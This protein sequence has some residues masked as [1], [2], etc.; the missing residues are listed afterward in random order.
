MALKRCLR[1]QIQA[2]VTIKKTDVYG[3]HS[4]D[5]KGLISAVSDFT[6][7]PL[8]LEAGRVPQCCW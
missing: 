8:F 4:T 2:G 3:P 1:E 7:A 5:T 6:E